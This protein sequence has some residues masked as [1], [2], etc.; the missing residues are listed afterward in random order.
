MWGVGC[1]SFLNAFSI[2]AIGTLPSFSQLCTLLIVYAMCACQI[3][4]RVWSFGGAGQACVIV[5]N[6]L[7]SL[8]VV[9]WQLLS[10]C[11]RRDATALFSNLYPLSLTT[12]VMQG[13]LV[14]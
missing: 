10:V 13:V 14:L 9:G 8:P 7:V 11:K 4:S 1:A 6:V 5:P 12:Q 2:Q 3:L